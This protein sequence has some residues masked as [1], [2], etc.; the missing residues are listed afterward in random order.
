MSLSHSGPPA[1]K[2]DETNDGHH[3]RFLKAVRGLAILAIFFGVGQHN[4][5]ALMNLAPYD[6]I[7]SSRLAALPFSAWFCAVLHCIGATLAVWIRFLVLAWA[8]PLHN[9]W[10]KSADN[11]AAAVQSAVLILGSAAVAM[12]SWGGVDLHS[13]AVS[14]IFTVLGWTALAGLC[15]GHRLVTRYRDHEEIENGNLA[16]AI[17]SAGLHLAIAI[18]VMNAIRGPFLGWQQALPAFM[19]AISWALLLW[20]LRQIVLARLILRIT[21]R[22]MDFEVS[23]GRDIWLGSAEGLCYVLSSLALL[24][25]W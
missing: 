18:V 24:A 21:P 14:A 23:A 12:S 10:T 20:P 1:Q 5:G 7:L 8:H 3:F 4:L 9:L 19:L 2:P 17:A 15:A 25:S 13:L 6:G 16:A 22:Q 11:S